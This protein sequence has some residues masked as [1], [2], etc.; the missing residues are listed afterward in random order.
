MNIIEQIEKWAVCSPERVAFSSDGK[1]LSYRS[2]WEESE[3]LAAWISENENAGEP[4]AVYGHKDPSM[5]ISF[6]A[7]VKSGHAYCPIDRSVPDQ[8]V[9][10][11]LAVLPSR[12]ILNTDEDKTIEA[13]NKE[14]VC[15]S[16]NSEQ[17]LTIR[18]DVLNNKISGRDKWVR[19]KNIFYIIFTSGSTGKPKGVQISANCLNNF[20][21]W[22]LTLGSRPRE[23]EGAVFLNQAPFS[24][25]LSVMDLYTS[26]A[27]GGSIYCLTK[28]KQT[29][30]KMLLNSLRESDAG[31][32]VSTPS[33]ADVCLSDPSF[34]QE[35]MPQL[36]TFLFCGETLSVKT[37]GKLMERF[38]D[39]KIINTY[40][41]TEST[42]A[43]TEVEICEEHLKMDALPVGRARE[44]SY[45]E[46]QGENGQSLEDG[47]R[48]E[49]IIYG[50]TVSPGYYG[51]ADLT[52]KVFFENEGIRAYHTGDEG[53]LDKG[54]LYYCGRKD[55]QVKLHGY[56]IELG[57]IE[58]NL[59][60]LAGIEQAA[61]LPNERGGRISSLTAYIHCAGSSETDQEKT[62]KYKDQLRELLPEYMIPKKFVY[63]DQMPM[64]GNGKLDRRA[65]RGEKK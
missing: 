22:S 48:G 63:V 15:I 47:Q 11:I 64:T 9:S 40:G 43:M 38:P 5:L 39:A 14:E 21:T 65:L 58:N 35:L 17:G 6:L 18:G 34:T 3:K 33:F 55:F 2:L 62:D 54:M 37:A 42:V 61:V 12:F 19:G 7:C 53:Y 52:D 36:G 13:E 16:W 56:R 60:K 1:T 28:E 44:G 51:R 20:L 4:V 30:F 23:K 49:I 10:D 45:L 8:R 24:F 57:D 31:Y 32:W 27:G 25:D 26:L 29:D 59:C 50:D 41:P 46:I